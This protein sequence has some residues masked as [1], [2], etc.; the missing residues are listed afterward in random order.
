[1]PE[2]GIGSRIPSTYVPF[3]NAHLLACGVSWAEVIGA[4]AVFIGANELDSSGYPDCREGFL[5][6]FQ[7]AVDEGTRPGSGIRLAWP[8]I[9][10]NKAGIVALGAKLAAPFDLTWSCYH[11]GERA[12]GRCESCL[13]RLKGF[14]E[15]HVTD[16]LPYEP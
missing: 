12:C 6:A 8:L 4:R 3:R 10:L 11:A 14:R 2:G 9:K 13:L 5:S 1:V 15:A 16:P 7:R